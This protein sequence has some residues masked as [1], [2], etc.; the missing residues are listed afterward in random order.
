[1]GRFSEEEKEK[2]RA[3]AKAAS[4]SVN[5]YIRTTAL[6]SDYRPP[7]NKGLTKALLALNLELTRQGNNLNQIAKRVNQGTTA[8]AEADGMLGIITRSMLQT[9]K[10]VRSALAAEPEPEPP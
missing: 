2:V 4:L 9:H 1:M 8:P 10:A 3:K 5:E 7:R 6:R